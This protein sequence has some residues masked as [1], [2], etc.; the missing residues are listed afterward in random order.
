MKILSHVLIAFGYS[1]G[2]L[3][4]IQQPF[5]FFVRVLRS[6][7]LNIVTLL[8]LPQ[9]GLQDAVKTLYLIL[10]TTVL[11]VSQGQ[12]CAQDMTNTGSLYIASATTC[13]MGSNFTNDAAA[14]TEDQGTIQLDGNWTNNGIFTPG[15]GSVV[16][17]GSSPQTM[18]SP[19][20]ETF[21]SLSIN[22][23][24][25][26]GVTLNNSAIVN[27][28][29]TLTDGILFTTTANLLTLIDGVTSSSGSAASFVDGPMKKIG[30]ET[31]VFPVGDNA[32][33][34]RLGISL[35]TTAT[36]E[37]TA[38]YFDV[39][40]SDLSV[41]G[42]LN[43]VSATEYW[44]LAQGVN[45]DDVQVTLYWEDAVRSGID[46]CISTD[47]VVAR[48]NGVDWEDE[49]QLAIACGGNVQSNTVVN[50]SPFTFGSE[51]GGGNPLPIELLDFTAKE[52]QG[53]VRVEWMTVSE[54]NNDFFTVERSANAVA[55]EVL[56]EVAGA[57]NSNG[58]LYYGTL[59]EQPLHGVSYYRLKQTD[60]DGSYSYSEIVA[61]NLEGIEL[62]SIYPVPAIDNIVFEVYSASNSTVVVEI[63][64]ERG[65]AVIRKSMKVDE[66]ENKL[67]MN[68]SA[69]AGGIYVLQLTTQSGMYTAVKG[70]VMGGD[71]QK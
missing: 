21:Y 18:T 38:Q 4:L 66:G 23:T 1:K 28:S 29:L 59:D 62:I 57:G 42:T 3:H 32:I 70:F 52:K 56:T 58:V 30:N 34:A 10:L 9:R 43:N 8:R 64:D 2:I 6:L 16:F 40:Y 5:A 51:N 60:F 22:N 41:T 48:Y 45:N 49:G 37:Y 19:G 44:T 47:L 7:Q 31:F 50:Y 12:V 14:T 36:T 11:A 27:S 26:T 55:F 68:I 17:S 39:V 33:W 61:V 20:G 46:D 24:S 35:P 63:K 13:F 54:I 53:K 25:A 69:I 65:R 15:T 67:S 71:T